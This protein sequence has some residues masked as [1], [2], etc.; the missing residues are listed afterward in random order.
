MKK[1]LVCF[2]FRYDV[3]DIKGIIAPLWFLL[4][5]LCAYLFTWLGLSLIQS[6]TKN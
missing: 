6:F 5:C 3:F 2:S 4:E 1:N